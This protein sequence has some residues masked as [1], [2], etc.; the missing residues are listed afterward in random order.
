MQ[1][2]FLTQHK[3]KN[4]DAELHRNLMLIELTGNTFS[5][6]KADLH[7]G[8]VLNMKRERGCLSFGK[9]KDRTAL[10]GRLVVDPHIEA[11]AP[12]PT[13]SYIS[14]AFCSMN[15]ID[16]ELIEKCVANFEEQKAERRLDVL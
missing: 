11:R 4:D 5:I 6:E 7:T 2:G 10:R 1:V 12:V 13:N 14:F 16:F 8:F 15:C 3:N 9:E